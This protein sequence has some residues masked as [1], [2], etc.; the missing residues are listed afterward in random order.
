M[1]SVQLYCKFSLIFFVLLTCVPGETTHLRGVAATGL[2][3]LSF[4]D[5]P[6]CGLVPLRS[7]LAKD[8]KGLLY[9][10]QTVRPN[11]V[12]LSRG[13]LKSLYGML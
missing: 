7:V 6:A 11:F 8:T 12:V 13:V 4:P 1:Q 10:E 2:A 5:G 3:W 9:H